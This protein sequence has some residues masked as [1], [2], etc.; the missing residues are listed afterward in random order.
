MTTHKKIILSTF[1][2]SAL[3]GALIAP[4]IANTRAWNWKDISSILP[5]RDGQAITFVSQRQQDALVSDGTNVYLLNA[6]HLTNLTARFEAA[7]VSRVDQLVSDGRSWMII[8]RSSQHPEGQVFLTNGSSIT[9]VS[10]LIEPSYNDIR[11][12]GHDGVWY[13]RVL[14]QSQNG[15]AN[16]WD[17]VNWNGL[18]SRPV[19]VNMPTAWQTDGTILPVF[20]NGGWFAMGQGL[21]W[22][23]DQNAITTQLSNLPTFSQIV[24]IW[25]SSQGALVATA[26]TTNTSAQADHLW[27]FDGSHW[28]DVTAQ[29]NTFGVLNVGRGNIHAAWTGDYWMIISGKKLIRVDGL[30][31]IDEGRTRDLFLSMT[32][33]ENGHLLLGGL[34]STGDNELASQPQTAKLVIVEDT[35]DT[36]VI[37]TPDMARLFNLTHGPTVTVRTSPASNHIGDGKTFVYQVNAT[38]VTGL[39]RI[40]LY[41]D[42][43]LIRTCKKSPCSFDEAYW[44]NGA[45]TRTVKFQARAVNTT[46]VSSL[47]PVTTLLVDQNSINAA[48]L[49]M[50]STPTIANWQTDAATKIQWATWLSPDQSSFDNQDQLVFSVLADHPK[51]IAS[52]DVWVNGT[53]V[54]TCDGQGLQ[55]VESC[56]LQ[57]NGSD[58]PVGT[59]VFVNAKIT[60]SN[61]L[62]AWT[63]GRTIVR[64]A[65]VIGPVV[66]PNSPIAAVSSTAPVQDFFATSVMT[67]DANAVARGTIV[68][69]VTRGQSRMFGLDRIEI[70]VN[71]S[72]ARS[73]IYG[74]AV[75]ITTCDLEL[76]T[77]QYFPGSNISITAHAI[78]LYG[79]ETWSNGKN[80]TV[81][82]QTITNA[83]TQASAFQTWSWLDPSGADIYGGQSATYHVGGW[84]ANGLQ[85]IEIFADGVAQQTCNAGSGSSECSY[86]FN[87]YSF[88]DG[89]TVTVSARLTDAK[90]LVSW[91]TPA[92]VTL[93]RTWQSPTNNE[94]AAVQTN[95]PN[96]Y[97]NG[98]AITFTARGW[99]P[100][101]I[102]HIE[103]DVNGQTAYSCPNDVCTW[104][105]GP[106]TNAF[107]EYE[108]R[109]VDRL[110]RSTWSPL[111]GIYR[112]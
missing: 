77:T 89:E 106:Q 42:G 92:S 87:P 100:N 44:T 17:L 14:H 3:L 56:R 9:N 107:V 65:D 37:V 63:N 108:A 31:F 22:R 55:H 30:Q 64:G 105:S 36:S 59:N 76:D 68:T 69:F 111:Q 86:S 110:G 24:N 52:I 48:A 7:G 82:S 88:N 29:A 33:D 98:Q 104:T 71:G 97:T 11:A 66:N 40:D 45:P 75:G 73:C 4:V 53:V 13:F 102:D 27:I 26:N 8:S 49:P 83:P 35:H 95:T 54:E 28:N 101:G 94:F 85:K 12:S 47:S 2:F 1:I 50:P 19:F 74:D 57:L 109:V 79:H 25:P 70:F 58:Y 78:D 15:Q 99:S 51:G 32:S 81:G 72:V 60:T 41:V 103:I 90:G 18:N 21:V 80:F 16:Q 62:S 67:P 10:T 93:H 38:D 39:K 23:V 61:G 5:H 6:G 46:N 20:I 96:G 34:V 43:A 91:S 112:N 84:S